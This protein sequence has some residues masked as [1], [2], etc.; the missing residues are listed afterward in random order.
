M[1]EQVVQ[2][3]GE[4]PIPGDFQGEAGASPGQLIELCIS[5]FIVG[6]LD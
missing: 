5:L 6:E 4:C 2:R 3:Y 1:L